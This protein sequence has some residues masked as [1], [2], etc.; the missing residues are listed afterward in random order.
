MPP[1]GRP[2]PDG[3]RVRA[4]TASLIQE[5]DVLASVS[6]YAGRPVIRRLNR[7]EYGNAIRDLLALDGPVAADLPDDGTAAGFDNYVVKPIDPTQF[8]ELLKRTIASRSRSA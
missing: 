5:L 4:F 7:T 8:I 6:P 1:P 2:R 3:L